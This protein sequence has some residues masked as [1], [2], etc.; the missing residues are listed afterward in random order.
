MAAVF[1]ETKWVLGFGNWDLIWA[2]VPGLMLWG[3]VL[4]SLWTAEQDQS[5]S[6][7][8]GTLCDRS[9]EEEPSALA[10]SWGVSLM[11]CWFPHT[12]SVH[13]SLFTMSHP[14]PWIPRTRPPI[15]RLSQSG[16]LQETLTSLSMCSLLRCILPG[17]ARSVSW[18][19]TFLC[20]SFSSTLGL[21]T[22]YSSFHKAFLCHF[23]LK[24]AV[25]WSPPCL[26]S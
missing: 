3:V 6:W 12:I 19:P 11:W 17:T 9:K 18:K 2:L 15:Q 23:C 16:A 20:T 13:S 14:C 24:L 21:F 25:P 5:Q 22:L 4:G 26:T 10:S 1:R 8:C 7:A